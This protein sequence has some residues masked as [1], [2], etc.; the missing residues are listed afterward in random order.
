MVLILKCL[1][2]SRQRHH[3][4]TMT[5]SHTWHEFCLLKLYLGTNMITPVWFFAQ[6]I[7]WVTLRFRQ[8]SRL[9]HLWGMFLEKW[10]I[11]G[12]V[13]FFFRRNQS[14]QNW[15]SK[16][17]D[18]LG[19]QLL[20]KREWPEQQALPHFTDKQAHFSSKR[21][22]FIFITYFFTITYPTASLTLSL[23]CPRGEV[24]KFFLQRYG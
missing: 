20:S 18:N 3:N 21:Q 5:T 8:L 22:S 9:I 7:I 11:S 2:H 12:G 24:C 4:V 10:A 13:S 1:D 6:K 19:P 15:N 17:G 16:A 14:Q 23:G